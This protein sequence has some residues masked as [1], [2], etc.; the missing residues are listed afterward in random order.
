MKREPVDAWAE[1]QSIAHSPAELRALKAA[2]DIIYA[3][4]RV[5]VDGRSIDAEEATDTMRVRLMTGRHDEAEA[6]GR[7]ITEAIVAEADRLL[8]RGAIQ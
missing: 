4:L 7:A 1:A 5:T 6:I 3:D 8:Q 2:G